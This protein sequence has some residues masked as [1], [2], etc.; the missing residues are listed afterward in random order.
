MNYY[1]VEIYVK[2]YN[3]DGC[4]ME[5]YEEFLL[6]HTEE[7]SE[8]DALKYYV[9]EIDPD[10]YCEDDKWT[11][12]Q[13]SAVYSMYDQ[14]KISYSEWKELDKNDTFTYTFEGVQDEV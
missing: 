7:V 11:S 6:K 3:A 2:Y 1:H 13:K 8:E 5:D 10:A 12:C 9:L 4:F 14:T